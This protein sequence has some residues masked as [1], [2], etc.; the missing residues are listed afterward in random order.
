MIGPKLLVRKPIAMG[1]FFVALIGWQYLIKKGEK[2]MEQQSKNLE[3]RCVKIFY[4]ENMLRNKYG[5]KSELSK[6]LSEF[7][8]NF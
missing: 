4:V 6:F 8:I 3:E 5:L 7:I 1:F 2:L